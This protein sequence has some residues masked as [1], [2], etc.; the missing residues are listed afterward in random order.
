MTNNCPSAKLLS[1]T[2]NCN[3]ESFSPHISRFVSWTPVDKLHFFSP[4][5]Q[6]NLDIRF[7]VIVKH[8]M[9]NFVRNWLGNGLCLLS[10]F[11]N[12]LP[13]GVIKIKG[14]ILSERRESNP[15]KVN[16]LSLLRVHKGR[17]YCLSYN[18]QRPGLLPMDSE[19]FK[20][21]IIVLGCFNCDIVAILAICRILLQTWFP[22]CKWLRRR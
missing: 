3:L 10:D 2:L 8:Y 1:S 9:V 5:C 11:F 7:W 16:Y 20:T 19:W 4:Q 14:G 17:A 21:V 12:P 13:P 22:W 15:C 18:Y 6:C